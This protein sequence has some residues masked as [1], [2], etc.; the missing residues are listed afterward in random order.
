[1]EDG[2]VL[3][4]DELLEADQ[5]VLSTLLTLIESREMADGT[6]LPDVQIIAATNDTI[7]SSQLKDNIKQRFMFMD[8]YIDKQGT[9]EYILKKTGL[10]LPDELMSR[11][12]D[13]GGGRNYNFLSPR[14]LTKLAMW[15]AK[16]DKDELFDITVIINRMFDMNIGTYLR[17][18][19]GARDEKHKEERVKAQVKELLSEDDLL[20]VDIDSMDIGEMAKF[21]MSLPDWDSISKELGNIDM[22]ENP[23][24]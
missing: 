24:Y 8:F 18:A 22:D 2:D 3:F 23:P 14:T 17:D 15:M 7:P 9:R 11:L 16:A 5:F 10:D 12:E 1:L 4:F 13:K 21:L 6:P 20:D 19:R